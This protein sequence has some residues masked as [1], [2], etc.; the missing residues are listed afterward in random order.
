MAAASSPPQLSASMA[1]DYDSSEDEWPYEHSIHLET[2]DEDECSTIFLDDDM[3]FS[4]KEEE[5][6]QDE[7]KEYRRRRTLLATPGVPEVTISLADLSDSDN[8]E[9]EKE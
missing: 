3:P 9:E 6:K 2:D 7:D 4:C 1:I 5:V 8:E